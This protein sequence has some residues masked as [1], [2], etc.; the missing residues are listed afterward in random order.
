MQAATLG[1]PRRPG[2]VRRMTVL[3]AVP[4]ETISQT[5][6]MSAMFSGVMGLMLQVRQSP[7]DCLHWTL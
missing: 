5:L 4:D 7:E 2:E 6:L 1:D 3:P